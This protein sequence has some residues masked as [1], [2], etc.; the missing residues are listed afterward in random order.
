[1]SND[2]KHIIYTAA[3][4]K[5]YLGGEMTAAEMHDI[6][7]AALDDP[8]LAEAMEGYELLEEQAVKKI[9][10]TLRENFNPP[11]DRTSPVIPVTKSPAYKWW[12]VA[13]AVLLVTCTVATAYIF[14][15]KN[16]TTSDEL[17]AI[18]TSPGSNEVAVQP[19]IQVPAKG[20]LQ[21]AAA[22]VTGRNEHAVDGDKPALAEKPGNIAM[23]DRTD[24]AFLYT[25][26]ATSTYAFN[27]APVKDEIAANGTYYK[28]NGNAETL[29][30]ASGLTNNAIAGNNALTEVELEQ[31][32][33]NISNK[34]KIAANNFSAQVVTADNKPIEFA[35]VSVQ[36]DKTPVYTDVNG[37]FQLKGTDS[38]VTVTISSPGYTAK[39]IELQNSVATKKIVLDSIDVPTETIATTSGIRRSGKRFIAPADSL[40]ED[41]GDSDAA[42]Y[43][44]WDEYNNYLTNNM[45]VPDDAKSKNF[46]GEVEV[47]AWLKNNGTVPQVKVAKPLCPGCDAEAVRLVKQGPRFEVKKNSSKK[48]KVKVKF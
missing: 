40:A 19:T 37:R 46:H 2:N 9:I 8:L 20:T 22:P 47:Y 14:T 17:A 26:S 12:R 27:D 13:A 16:K 25:P 43:G 10:S 36:K 7:K 35:N 11:Q 1:M 4:I 32:Q 5:R 15:N 42:P 38:I 30:E 3:D 24:S 41:D 23:E 21:D 39:K 6:E 18:T 34:S 45:V 48:V 44:G 29:K 33:K 28:R 31:P